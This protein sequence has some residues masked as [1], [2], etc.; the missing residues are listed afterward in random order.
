MVCLVWAFEVQFTGY[1]RNAD[2]ID[3]QLCEKQDP[4]STISEKKKAT[5]CPSILHSV[6]YCLVHCSQ[7]NIHEGIHCERNREGSK[8]HPI[9]EMP[10][11]GTS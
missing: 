4:E 11:P 2:M 8:P 3:C 5:V 6:A 7:N 10:E 9:V 1:L